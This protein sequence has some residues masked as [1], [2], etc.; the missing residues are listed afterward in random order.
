[1]IFCLFSRK[2][3]CSW[4]LKSLSLPFLVNYLN[5]DE[6]FVYFVRGF[7]WMLE[8][9]IISY[10]GYQFWTIPDEEG[11]FS[12]KNVYAGNYHFYASVPG[13]IGDN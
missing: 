7:D 3:D 6:S 11:C 2:I 9:Y 5:S 13:V 8:V 4:Y 10:Q 12:I 1:M